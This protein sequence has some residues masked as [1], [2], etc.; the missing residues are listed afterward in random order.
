MEVFRELFRWALRMMCDCLMIAREVGIELP[1]E[2]PECNKVLFFIP[3]V[4]ASK[5]SNIADILPK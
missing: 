4:F 1:S 2:R 5:V 3:T